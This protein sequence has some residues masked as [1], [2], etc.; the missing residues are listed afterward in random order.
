MVKST[1]YSCRELRLVP[2]PDSGLQLSITLVPDPTVHSHTYKQNT[3][4]R[5]I[6]IAGT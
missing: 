3:H 5:K 6:E 4:T 2:S 1:C